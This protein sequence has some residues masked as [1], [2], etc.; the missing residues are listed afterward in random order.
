MNREVEDGCHFTSGLISPE[1]MTKLLLGAIL[2]GSAVLRLWPVTQGFPDLYVHDEIFEAKR[3]VVLLR[4]H[5]DSL[6]F[7]E[8]RPAKAP[9]VVAVP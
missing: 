7:E 1:R 2:L 5:Y 9:N 6:R 8:T 4:G 3:A